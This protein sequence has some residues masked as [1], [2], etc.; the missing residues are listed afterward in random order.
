MNPQQQSAAAT[1]PLPRLLVN[2]GSGRAEFREKLKQNL[3]ATGGLH[4]Q[5]VGRIIPAKRN[6][7]KPEATSCSSSRI[8]SSEAQHNGYSGC[9]HANGQSKRGTHGR[10]DAGLSGRA[11][12]LRSKNTGSRTVRMFSWP[13]AVKQHVRRVS[14]V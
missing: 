11:G 13:S 12:S 8:G 7:L 5:R 6:G 1:T 14:C 3:E 4:C 2:M 10:K 9:G